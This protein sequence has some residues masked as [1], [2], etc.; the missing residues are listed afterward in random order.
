MDD[1]SK[2]IKAG[3]AVDQWKLR[4]YRKAIEKAG[5]EIASTTPDKGKGFA[6]I[7]VMVDEKSKDNLAELLKKLERKYSQR[8]KMN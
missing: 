7:T 4:V 2:K 5:F 1:N 6:L 3:V 8:N